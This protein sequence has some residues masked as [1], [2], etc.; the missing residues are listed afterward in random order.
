[1][2]EQII[3]YL[4]ETSF[5]GAKRGLGVG[6]Y[7]AVKLLKNVV[8]EAKVDWQKELINPISL[9]VDE[10]SF[11]GHDMMVTL[12]NLTAPGLITILP[13]AKKVTIDMLLSTIPGNLKKNVSSVAIDMKA[14][15]KLSLKKYLP[16]TKIT[17]DHFH[18]IYDANKRLEE[19]RRILQNV[20]QAKIPRWLFIKN[21]EN[22]TQK[23]RD[24]AKV[25][26][27]KYSDLKFYWFAKESLREMYKLTSRRQAE[28][29]L[30]N[31]IRVMY[32]GRDSGLTNWADM[33][34]NWQDEILNFF[35]TKI[36]NAY[37]EG[38]NTKLKLIKRIGFGFRNK[39]VYI[40]KAILAFTPFTI[41]PHLFN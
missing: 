12:T 1:M 18:V 21:K 3:E 11:S 15:Y 8:N 41:I 36:T 10:H 29:K 34:F 6:Y 28:E 13:D 2:D 19:E 32:K 33:L 20:F 25:I 23:E 16:N 7:S 35:D 4:K 40:K 31:L 17:V 24:L 30:T 14:M 5:A 38:V 27:E 9:G 22:L 26:F 39:E 37:T